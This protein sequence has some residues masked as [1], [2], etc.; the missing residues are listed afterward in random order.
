MRKR[1][2]E[3]FKQLVRECTCPVNVITKERVE[4]FAARARAYICTYHY[5]D[6]QQFQRRESD[7]LENNTINDSCPRQELLSF[8]NIERLQKA[9]KGHRCALDFDSGFVNSMLKEAK[10]ANDDEM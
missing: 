3:N 2:R 7:T 1:G 8:S 6:T 5:L 10:K 9:L 4:K